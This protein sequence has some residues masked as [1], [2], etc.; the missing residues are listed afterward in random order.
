M[1]VY[2]AV[3]LLKEEKSRA[4]VLNHGMGHA[5]SVKLKANGTRNKKRET[6]IVIKS[7][8]TWY[9]TNKHEKH[10]QMDPRPT[11]VRNR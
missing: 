1:A 6:P 9:Y 10:D 7:R 4:H 8:A 11:S 2:T 5:G 3:Q